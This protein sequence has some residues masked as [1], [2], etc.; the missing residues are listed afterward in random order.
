MTK[1]FRLIK[2]NITTNIVEA[3]ASY[4]SQDESN[5]IKARKF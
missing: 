3:V 5:R 2:F 1:I 4:E